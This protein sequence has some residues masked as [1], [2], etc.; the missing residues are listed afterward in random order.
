MRRIAVSKRLSR[1]ESMK[2]DKLAIFGGFELHKGLKSIVR[3]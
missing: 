2:V 3:V 1:S